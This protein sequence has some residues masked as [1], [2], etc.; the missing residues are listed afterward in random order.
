VLKVGKPTGMMFG[1]ALVIDMSRKN[2]FLKN[3]FVER[4]EWLRKVVNSLANCDCKLSCYLFNL[5]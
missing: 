5:F 3:Q 2:R 4:K 1:L